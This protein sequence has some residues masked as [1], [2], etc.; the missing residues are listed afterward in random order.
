MLINIACLEGDPDRL[1]SAKLVALRSNLQVTSLK[2][3][4]NAISDLYKFKD[5][6][7]PYIGNVKATSDGLLIPSIGNLFLWIVLQDSYSNIILDDFGSGSQKNR[8]SSLDSSCRQNML[9]KKSIW[10]F[11]NNWSLT[12]HKTSVERLVSYY[13]NYVGNH[14]EVFVYKKWL[15]AIG[16]FLISPIHNDKNLRFYVGI[17]LSCLDSSNS[18]KGVLETS[19]V[20]QH[21][22]N[23]L[24][25][26]K[27]EKEIIFFVSKFMNDKKLSLDTKITNNTND[28]EYPITKVDS[29]TKDLLKNYAK[30]CKLH[31]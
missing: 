25:N 8:M 12:H 27:L 19:I 16:S 6:P 21:N 9:Y 2:E 3:V 14:Q 24:G 11:A 23:I 5:S 30:F 1:S 20:K 28:N 29:L 17:D 7:L 31:K 13:V 22:L 18:L 26:K 4:I 10:E 15:K